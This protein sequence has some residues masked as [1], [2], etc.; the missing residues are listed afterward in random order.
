MTLSDLE[1]LSKIFNDTKRRVVSATAELLVLNYIAIWLLLLLQSHYRWQKSFII[2]VHDSETFSQ[3]VN[4]MSSL[5]CTIFYGAPRIHSADYAV[6]RCLSVRLSVTRRYWSK[7]L[8][9]CSKFFSP[10]GSPTI[11][12]FSYQKGYK[13]S[14]GNPPNRG[15]ECKGVWK[16]S[17]FSTNISLYLDCE[18]FSDDTTLRC[19]CKP[20]ISRL[21]NAHTAIAA[22]FNTQHSDG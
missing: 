20:L 19:L 7:R 11:L 22:A 13:Y 16:K 3:I 9:I 14:D 2:V 10:S 18:I 8:Y 21:Y 1:W 12:V 5:S 4:S 6:A 15:S 17:R